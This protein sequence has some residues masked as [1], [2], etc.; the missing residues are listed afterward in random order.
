VMSLVANGDGAYTLRFSVQ[1]QLVS[2]A[3]RSMA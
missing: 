3:R 1:R 2:H